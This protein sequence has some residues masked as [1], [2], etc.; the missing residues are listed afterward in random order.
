MVDL[1]SHHIAAHFAR[2]KRALIHPLLSCDASIFDPKTV[3]TVPAVI[4]LARTHTAADGSFTK[5]ARVVEC[6]VR[7]RLGT[8]RGGHLVRG[9]HAACRSR[10]PFAVEVCG[11]SGF[12][13]R[14]KCR[15]RARLQPL[16]SYCRYFASANTPG[17]GGRGA[18]AL[19]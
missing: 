12:A 18:A 2:A 6:G 3:A 7:V 4:Y 8:A 13:R 11:R 1:P 16:F 19:K 9:V 14:A 15:L 17:V 5:R 10:R